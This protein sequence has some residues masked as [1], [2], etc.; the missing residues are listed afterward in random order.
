MVEDEVDVQT[1]QWLKFVDEMKVSSARN[2]RSMYCPVHVCMWLE[3]ADAL[4]INRDSLA[5]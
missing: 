3:S 4:I 2:D 1:A 5:K